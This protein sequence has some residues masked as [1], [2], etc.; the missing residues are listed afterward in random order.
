MVLKNLNKYSGLFTEYTE[1]RVQENRELV[2][3]YNQ[4]NLVT[5]KKES[6]NGVSARVYKGGSWGFASMPII[7]DKAI[8]TVI[9]EA[10]ENALFLNSKQN[11]NKGSLPKN[12]FSIEKDFTTD[13]L[14]LSQK[15]LMAFVKE[16][17]NY[18]KKKYPKLSNRVVGLNSLE[19]EKSLLTSHGSQLYSMLPRTNFYVALTIER[20][21]TPIDMYEIYG[22]LGQFEDIF[23]KP[24]DLYS[25]IDKLYKKLIEK[26]EG[27]YTEAGVKECILDSDLAGILAHEAIG[28]TTEAD[29]VLGGSI[30]ADYL[31][32]K[33]AS[34]LIT[35]VDFANTYN[36]ETCP[37]PIY[38]DDEGTKTEDAVIIEDGVLKEYMNNK[39]S[40]KY[41]D[42]KPKGNARAYKYN[43][44]PLVRMRN[45][46]I[47]PGKSKLE[48][49]IA[50]I[51]DG[52]YLMKPSNGQADMTS[53]FMF[54][55][56]MGYEIKNG[57][58]GRAIKDT[59]ISGVAFDVLKS[60]T[61]VS[62]DMTWSCGGMCGK[63][64]MITVGMG[65]PAIKCKVNIG[66]R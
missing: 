35:L 58:L 11:K 29:M 4:G 38:I 10:K 39:E 24:E 45:T 51:D 22:G 46:A 47:L 61:M 25:D 62:D 2:I 7:D 36:N 31:N 23:N 57:K 43:D 14:R 8:E 19:M 15:E 44:E 66:G 64:Q 52:Y 16:V 17:D 9:N 21:G 33:V 20:D 54:G 27:V 55:V 6:N 50:S 48:D 59:T 40:A 63:K 5:N 13:K 53:E 56:T 42:V 18:I 3:M 41:F 32:E 60:V 30:A 34:E 26:S 28:H 65:G 49:M 37:V 12:S 1:L